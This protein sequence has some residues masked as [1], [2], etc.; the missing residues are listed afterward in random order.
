LG[1]EKIV[2]PKDYSGVYAIMVTPFDKQG[3]LDEASLRR[4]V[5]F[6]VEGGA[7]GIV[8][9][10]NASESTTLT[11]QERVRIA[12][13]TVEQTARRIPVVI[14]VSGTSTHHSAY[15]AQQASAVEADALIAMP[16]YVRK[17]NPSDQEIFDYYQTL[18]TVSRLPIVVQDFIAPVGTPMSIG[19]LTRLFRDIDEVLYLKEE[20][21]LAGQKMTLLL[22]QAGDHI[23]G[24]MGGAAGRYLL[25]EHRRGAVGT[26]PACEV[27]DLHAQLWDLL[28]SNRAEAARSFYTKLLPLLNIESLYS[29]AIYKEVLYRRGIIATTVSRMPGAGTLDRF[30]HQELD[31]ILAELDA[32]FRI[33]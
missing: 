10:V 25:D 26:M 1:S 28:E 7:R 12:A 17:S 22:E 24:I 31:A 15:L 30:D 6:C 23:Q 18:A 9:P 14:G 13:I 3:N 33:R 20:T 8:T 29:F 19:L 4:C 16:P 2:Q 21:A 11:D 32:D 5:D 27:I